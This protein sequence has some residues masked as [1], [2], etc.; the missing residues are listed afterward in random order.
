MNH[1]VKIYPGKYEIVPHGNITYLYQKAE[2]MQPKDFRFHEK[3]NK[4]A[5][6]QTIVELDI[7]NDKEVKDFLQAYGLLVNTLNDPENPTYL[8]MPISKETNKYISSFTSGI[9]MPKYLF[10][11][12]I[13]LLKNILLLSTEISK[14]ECK[15]SDF[16]AEENITKILELFL[17]LLFQPYTVWQNAGELQIIIAGITP[18]SRFAAS[19]HEGV[20]SIP[21]CFLD[22]FLSFFVEKFRKITN[23]NLYKIENIPSI[24]ETPKE[25]SDIPIFEPTTCFDEKLSAIYNG[26]VTIFDL[27]FP[28]IF[29]EDTA[30]SEYNILSKTLSSIAKYCNYN[31]L[32]NGNIKLRFKDKTAFISD[33]KLSENLRKLS[34]QLIIDTLNTY[35][36]NI[37]FKLDHFN[38]NDLTEEENEKY[39]KTINMYPNSN[40]Y[41][42]SFTYKSPSLLQALFLEASRMLNEYG[43]GICAYS[44]CN[45]IFFYKRTRPKRCCCQRHN[46]LYCKHRKKIPKRIKKIFS[47]I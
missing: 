40:T 45:K 16:N 27:N 43:V 21:S 5:I 28:Q 36:S 24:L 1:V 23:E 4:E 38:K 8:G 3:G 14:S 35:T 9:S 2:E 41:M 10:K 32:R 7:D 46:D 12:N 44:E 25:E 26:K 39:I 29:Y 33:M 34:K 13:K 42:Y 18:L 37:Q 19:Y 17:S 20:Y 22:D 30:T 47:F 31:F 15:N 11:H 6:M